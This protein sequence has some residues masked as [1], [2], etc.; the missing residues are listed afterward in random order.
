MADFFKEI[1]HDFFGSQPDKSG[2]WE[3]QLIL[4]KVIKLLGAPPAP[5]SACRGA[6]ADRSGR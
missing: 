5:V 6:T 4:L 3:E 1:C 2:H